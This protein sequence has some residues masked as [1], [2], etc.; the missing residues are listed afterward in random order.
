M[1]K[2]IHAVL[3]V[4]LQET[5]LGTRSRLAD[6]MA[7]QPVLRR[8]VARV[9]R[10]R[11][12]DQVFVLAPSAQVERCKFLLSGL[13]AVVAPHD[14]GP[15]PWRTLV[16]TARKWSLDGWRG[17]LG[18]TTCF[19]EFTDARLLAG[20]LDAAPADAVL[21]VPPSAVVFDPG[22]ADQMVAHWTA[23]AMDSRL[24]F[25][26]APP[27]LAGILLDARLVRELIEKNTPIGWLFGYQPDHP[28]KDLIFESCCCPSPVEVRHAVGRLMADTQRSFETLTALLK[29][30]PD[31]DGVVA[32][33]W[34][35]SR[36]R[37]Y[38]PP[39]PRE[40]EIELTTDDPLPDTLIRPR[41]R[42][43]PPRGPIDLAIVERIA[44]ELATY[45]DSLVVLGGFG[46]PLR[47]P[48]FADVLGILRPNA[49]TSPSIYGVAVRTSGVDLLEREVSG[50]SGYAGP[51]S[52]MATSNE[53][54]TQDPST[55]QRPRE[56]FMATLVQHRVDV[57]NVLF[58]AWSP[59]TYSK[60]HAL[61]EP[62]SVQLP[63]VVRALD[64]MAEL[65]QERGSAYPILLPEFTKSRDNAHELDE[66][67]DGWLRRNGAV[68]IG[69][70]SHHA[71]QMP[72][73][74]VMNMA[75]AGRT[76][77]RRIASRC[78]VLADGRLTACDQDYAGRFAAGALRP[79]PGT[80]GPAA[81]SLGAIW[82]GAV[83]LELRA[84]HL[85]GRFDVNALCSACEEWQR[86]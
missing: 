31:P 41:G 16:Q 49:M 44:N 28:R 35:Q 64:R 54:Q 24:T 61:N 29:D 4:D 27:G 50:R 59:A 48:Q 20:L 10:A 80:N 7:G 62:E 46:D 68:A 6:A 42:R 14:G 52:P 3:E 8:T 47:H 9:L 25:V 83:L 30:H 85:A 79:P 5:P 40:V 66:F 72:D 78:M 34:L 32:G 73:R 21:S 57:L 75:P 65:R 26:Q 81:E 70:Y 76:Y 84:A 22:M 60:V 56:A 67:H 33:R 74:R 36:E 39:L 58:D 18:G 12:I 19:D 13:D 63:A 43:V 11:R 86:P 55:S 38:V 45:D 77:C 37:N 17:G 51:R 23:D 69:G 2:R 53:S 1:S 71:G 82:N 15:S